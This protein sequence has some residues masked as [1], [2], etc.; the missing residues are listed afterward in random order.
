LSKGL[1]YT[2]ALLTAHLLGMYLRLDEIVPVVGL[3]AGAIGLVEAK[4]IFENL[5]V[6]HG[7]NLFRVVIDRLGSQMTSESR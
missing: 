7:Q 5:S 2:V 4:S 6:I 3:V 1:V